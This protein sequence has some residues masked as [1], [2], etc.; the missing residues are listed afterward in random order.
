MTDLPPWARDPLSY[1]FMLKIIF[2][3]VRTLIGVSRS[4]VLTILS[5]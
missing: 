2:V 1:S 5:K 3:E 4:S